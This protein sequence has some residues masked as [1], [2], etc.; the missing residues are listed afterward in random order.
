[1]VKRAYV[2]LRV[3]T[4][5]QVE[6]KSL[7]GQLKEIE[8]YCKA[9]NIEIV[10]V[11]SDEGKS[12]KSIEGRPQ[13][14]QLL[15][16]VE[17]KEEVEYII[18]WKL[19]RFGRNARETLNSLEFLQKHNCNLIAKEEHL[20]SSDKNGR[21]MIT[22]LSAMAEMERENI[23]EQ[24]LNGKKY[25]ALSGN[26]NGGMAPYG[27]S[28]VDTNLI[29][30]EEEANIVRKIFDWYVNI[31]DIGYNGVTA[32]L[33]E[34]E[35]PPRQIPRLD[36]QAMQ[37]SDSDE[38]IYLPNVTSW[39]STQVKKIL[40]NPVYCGKIR[41]GHSRVVTE[42]G[43]SKR[44]YRGDETLVD[45][46]HEAI[47]SEELFQKAQDKYKYNGKKFHDRKPAYES[48]RNIL[49]QI[50]RCPQCGR[51]MVA[52]T[53]RY[54]RKNGEVVYYYNYI[55]S[56][57]NNHKNGGCKK[58]AIKADYL[59]FEVMKTIK[60]YLQRPNVVQ[61][62]TNSLSTQFDT[63]KLKREIKQLEKELKS[64]EKNE[65]IQYNILCQ[66]GLEGKYQNWSFEKVEKN[67]ELLLKNKN[68]IELRLQEK[69]N[70]LQIA[71]EE[72]L[73]A[74]SIKFILEHFEDAL[75]FASKDQQRQLLRSILKEV[76]LEQREVDG[77]IKVLPKSLTLKVTGE[78]IN[79]VK[80]SLG[81]VESEVETVVL[82]S[83][84]KST[85]T[86][87]VDLELS[88]LDLTKAEAKA[89][90]AEIKQ[91]VFDKFGMKVSQLYIAQVKRE[92]GLIER[93]NYNVGEGKNK[94]PQVTPEKR[95]AIIDALKFYQMI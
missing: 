75:Q 13:F 50:A 88:E 63:S 72:E 41:W 90:Y 23:I 40:T 43:I 47:I 4:L 59:E 8:A 70:E 45:G 32:M 24:T 49:N 92:F 69:R 5:I 68:S 21:F 84:L 65:E 7:E 66:V 26:W 89:T 85:K 46:N 9:Y 15:K 67:I 34:H 42:D 3:S 61:E 19:S 36:R 20:D 18:V 73:D 76:Q 52:C 60:E 74:E 37:E 87:E 33:N 53:S 44:A 6:G 64:L 94:V 48:P 55:C 11:Y 28:L 81:S 57:F 83:K 58:N 71:Q 30:N 17:E 27:Y 2:Y 39:Y 79:V 1:M 14:K 56:F 78:Q 16:D 86:I 82:L 51:G 62:I 29:I 31:E 93:I 80:E 91:Y 54:K 38:K 95:E 12:G 77:K 25:N 35:I 22:L 10:K